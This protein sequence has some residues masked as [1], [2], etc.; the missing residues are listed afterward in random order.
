MICESSSVRTAEL[1]RVLNRAT[2]E[3]QLLLQRRPLSVTD[4]VRR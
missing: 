2:L 4:A 1:K 3:R